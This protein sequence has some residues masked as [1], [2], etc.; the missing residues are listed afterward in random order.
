MAD[1]TTVPLSVK[2]PPSIKERLDA[3][4]DKNFRS[5]TSQLLLILNEYFAKLDAIEARKAKRTIETVAA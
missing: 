4:A 2:I 5:T 1:E 3:E